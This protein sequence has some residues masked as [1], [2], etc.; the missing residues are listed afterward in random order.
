MEGV[1]RA[2]RGCFPIGVA[3]RYMQVS[4]F[5][6][7]HSNISNNDNFFPFMGH[8]SRICDYKAN[9]LKFRAY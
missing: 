2:A 6:N 4:S 3:E 9:I 7:N 8:G 1:A 5:P